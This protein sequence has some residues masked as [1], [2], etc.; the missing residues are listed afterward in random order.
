MCAGCIYF[1]GERCHA[2]GC[3]MRTKA[4]SKFAE[5]PLKKWGQIPLE[6]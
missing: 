2:C 5:C 1:R 4:K 6:G 3:F